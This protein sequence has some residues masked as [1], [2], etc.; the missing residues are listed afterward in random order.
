MNLRHITCHMLPVYWKKIKK[1]H[2]IRGLGF[3][4]TQIGLTA[5]LQYKQSMILPR[6]YSS[7]KKLC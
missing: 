7:P 4:T 6:K 1:M 5:K 3:I 2:H